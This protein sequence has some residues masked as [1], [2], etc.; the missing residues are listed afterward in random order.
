MDLFKSQFERIQQQLSGLTPTQKMLSAALVTIMVM[1]LWLSGR[2]AAAPEMEPLLNQQLSQDDVARI[3]MQLQAAGIHHTMSPDGKMLVPADRKIQAIANLGY[4]NLMPKDFSSGFDQIIS[5]LTAWDGNDRQNAMFNRG[6][7]LTLEQVI[8]QFPG[9]AQAKVVIG[10]RLVP[11]PA[12]GSTTDGGIAGDSLM[13]LKIHAEKVLSEKIRDY[14][15]DISEVRVAVSVHVTNSTEARD[16]LSYDKDGSLI[17]ELETTTRSRDTSS[18]ANG[19]AEAGAV[20]NTGSSIA[21]PAAGSDRSDTDA[22]ENTKHAVFAGSKRISVRTPAG[23]A[24][25]AGVSVRLPRSWLVLVAKGGNP[26]GAEPDAAAMDK[27]ADVQAA[28]IRKALIPVTQL[29]APD[30]INVDTYFDVVAPAAVATAQMAGVGTLTAVV[31]GHVKEIMLGGLAVV[32]LIMM[33]MM[34]RKGSN[35]LPAPVVAAAPAARSP[36]PNLV[37]SMEALVGEV[38]TQDPTLDGMEL[39]DDA[40]RTQ[41]MLSQVTSLVGE[42]PDTAAQLVKRWMNQR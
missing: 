42:N 10:G 29:S 7:E 3:G 27:A 34:V 25:P 9:V 5:K 21:V 26:A 22:T 24:T 28:K 4:A 31:G 16:T 15:S 12:D 1:T 39:D 11:V 41:Q 33:S 35:P 18:K 13:D 40:I 8:S 19:P 23:Q 37:G 36:F 17:T 6:K 32:S 2:Y 14:L 38:S 20:P 30:A